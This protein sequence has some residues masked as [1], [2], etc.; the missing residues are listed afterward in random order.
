M[1]RNL[2]EKIVSLV[3][4]LA[5]VPHIIY[6]LQHSWTHRREAFVPQYPYEVLTE[7]S[8]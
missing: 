2:K 1:L 4:I 3:F 6:F 7:E 5:C 8:D